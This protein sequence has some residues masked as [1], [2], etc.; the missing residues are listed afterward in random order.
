M[1]VLSELIGAIGD[2]ALMAKIKSADSQKQV[3]K[4]MES[5]GKL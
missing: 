3:I 4:A 1:N 5:S 2:K